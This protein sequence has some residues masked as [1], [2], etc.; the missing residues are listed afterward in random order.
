MGSGLGTR[1]SINVAIRDDIIVEDDETINI[2][3]T[4]QGTIGS[5]SGGG[6]TANIDISIIDNDYMFAPT[7]AKVHLLPLSS[8]LTVAL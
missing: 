5:F 6:V 2:Q 7:Y 8:Q 1:R 3:A 4:I